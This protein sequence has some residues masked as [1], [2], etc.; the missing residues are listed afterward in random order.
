MQDVLG[1]KAVDVVGNGGPSVGPSQVNNEV[2][3]ERL[4]DKGLQLL[5]DALHITHQQTLVRL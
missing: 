3:D 1:M 2:G 4:A 5:R